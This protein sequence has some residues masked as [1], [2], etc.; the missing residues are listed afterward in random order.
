MQVVWLADPHP[1]LNWTFPAPHTFNL[2]GWY[3]AGFLI[4]AASFFT[5]A[6]T[7]ILWRC[8]KP[9]P[10]RRDGIPAL[11]AMPGAAV[12]A[13]C[14]LGFAGLVAMDSIGGDVTTQ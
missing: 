6:F 7:L 13:G 12:L 14:L 10:E 9:S 11:M 3:H 2:V 5:A 8:R 1:Q 4:A